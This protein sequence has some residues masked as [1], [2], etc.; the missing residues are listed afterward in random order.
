MFSVLSSMIVTGRIELMR[1]GNLL[2]QLRS[3]ILI[4]V[5]FNFNLN[6]HMGLVVMVL[7]SVGQRITFLFHFTLL[8]AL[9]FGFLSLPDSPKHLKENE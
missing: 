1:T 4:L 3:W 8:T 5:N 2:L 7:G 6:G 9:V